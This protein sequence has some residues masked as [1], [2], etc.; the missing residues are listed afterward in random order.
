MDGYYSF[1]NTEGKVGLRGGENKGA[2]TNKVMKV[3]ISGRHTS[4]EVQL[5]SHKPR[6]L[7]SFWTAP[8]WFFSFFFKLLISLASP[9]LSCIMQTFSCSMW[10]LAP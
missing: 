10:D 8:Q 4:K 2:I 9:G 3:E 5:F 6:E 1:K 7:A